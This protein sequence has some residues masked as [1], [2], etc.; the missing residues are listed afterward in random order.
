MATERRGIKEEVRQTHYVE[1][2]EAVYHKPVL[3]NHHMQYTNVQT[4]TQW[5]VARW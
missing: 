5:T 3:C 4:Q 2:Q 1:V